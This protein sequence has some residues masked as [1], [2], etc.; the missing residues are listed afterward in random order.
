MSETKNGGVDQYGAGRQ[1]Q[2]ATA[3]VD[4]VN[5][6]ESCCDRRIYFPAD[7]H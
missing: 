2:F 5:N 6:A 1:P 4:G 7:K 3:G